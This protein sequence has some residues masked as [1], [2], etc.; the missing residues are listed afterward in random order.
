MRVHLH[1]DSEAGRFADLLLE[2]GNGT[3]TPESD[4]GEVRL[5]V[6]FGNLVTTGEELMNKVYPNLSHY[7]KDTKWLCKRAI[8]APK[9]D[10]VEAINNS[11]HN[12]LPG[13]ETFFKSVC[14]AV[15]P[16]SAVQNPTEFMNSLQPLGLPPHNLILK[17]EHL[18]CFLAT[19]IHPDCA[20]GHVL[21]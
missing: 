4:D 14:S 6:G 9:N 19:W 8:L 10:I 7:C 3:L 18:S 17:L 11:L 12:N 13:K 15:D 21:Q 1:N 5:P 20:T 2:V 16:N